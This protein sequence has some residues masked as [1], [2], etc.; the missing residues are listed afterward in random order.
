[1]ESVPE[2]LNIALHGKLLSLSLPGAPEWLEPS[3]EAI[4]KIAGGTPAVA[5]SFIS[6]LFLQV[7]PLL[8]HS[9]KPGGRRGEFS[10]WQTFLHS[11]I[12]AS[13][14]TYSAR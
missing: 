5:L 3:Q 7:I 11:L 10:G 6:F 12:K 8:E 14:P 4:E 9:V 2:R 1:M 13:F